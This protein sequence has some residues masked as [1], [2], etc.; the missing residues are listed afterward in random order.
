VLFTIDDQETGSETLP[1]RGSYHGA[2]HPANFRVVYA[3]RFGGINRRHCQTRQKGPAQ[4]PG[5]TAELRT[6]LR[7]HTV[8]VGTLAFSPDVVV[9]V[10]CQFAW[11][12]VA[13]LCQAY[14]VPFILGHALFMKALHGGKSKN[15]DIDAEKIARLLRGGNLSVAYVYPRGLRDTRDLLRRRMHLVHK[16]PERT[17]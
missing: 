10:E 17:L 14:H 7:G 2:N 11:Y 13:D 9:A 15:E 6:T 4:T 1:L 12:W 3:V 5:T 16:R 8:G